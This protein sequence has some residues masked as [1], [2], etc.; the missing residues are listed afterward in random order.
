MAEAN[1]NL[2]KDQAQAPRTNYFITPLRK[3]R[4][5]TDPDQVRSLPN[6]NWV[7]FLDFAR[8][9]R[10]PA[11]K[12][13]CINTLANKKTEPRLSKDESDRAMAFLSYKGDGLKEA[14]AGALFSSEVK[15]L[16]GEEFL[17]FLNLICNA[18]EDKVTGEQTAI[19]YLEAIG[20]TN[21]IGKLV[22]VAVFDTIRTTIGTELFHKGMVEHCLLSIA[23]E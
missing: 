15:I 3:E 23:T 12:N 1:K 2:N 9:I 16:T 19:E 6:D 20:R 10:S 21:D 13:F 22:N 5:S 17:R 14:Y 4:L 11:I 7:R 18:F 8:F